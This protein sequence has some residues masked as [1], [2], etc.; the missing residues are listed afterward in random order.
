MNREASE[1]PFHSIYSHGFV[2]VAVC[3]PS[4]RVADPE[5]N[6]ERTLELARRAS[7]VLALSASAL[8]S[9]APRS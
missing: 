5:Y 1:R 6:G 3:V 4:V 7:E 2:R 9:K 8:A